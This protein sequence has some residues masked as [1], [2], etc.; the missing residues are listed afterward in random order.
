MIRA[1]IQARMSSRRFPGK[2]LA[3]FHGRPVIAW[4]IDA[5]TRVMP[6]TAVTVLTSTDPSD[7]P[8]ASYV[9]SLRIATFRGA[10]DDVFGRFRGA[11]VLYPC[12]WFVRL[13]S[14]SPLL[15]PALV[16]Q[17]VRLSEI[18]GVDLIT[19]V[20]PRTFPKGMSVELVRTTRF[21]AIDP[22]VL[23]TEQR[24][25]VTACYYSRPEAFRIRN[26]ASA[27]PDSG[28]SVAID[29][30]DDLQRLERTVAAGVLDR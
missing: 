1:F 10:L 30:L 3:P 13:C 8:L 4:L 24:E 21:R 23:S 7:D 22:A 27:H 28:A 17:A 5:V 20:F 29:S 19:N 16:E 18:A 12:D 2:V 11:L 6:P 9:D 14:D 26:F 15:D 25:H